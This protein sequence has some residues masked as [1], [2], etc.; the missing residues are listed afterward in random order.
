MANRLLRYIR[1]FGIQLVIVS[2]ATTLQARAAD[3]IALGGAEAGSDNSYLYAGVVRPLQ[4]STLGNGAVQR[5][6]V[7]RTTYTYDGGNGKIDA[8]AWGVEAALG[9][10]GAHD[11]TW[12]GTYAALVYRDT[13]L[14]PDDPSSRAR[15]GNLRAKVQVE[16]E[17]PLSA[18]WRINGNASYV[19]GQQNYWVRGRLLYRLSGTLSTGPEVLT[20]GDPDY[21]ISQVGWVVTGL[22]PTPDLDLALKLGA[23]KPRGE[24]TQ[25]Y[26]GI[27]LS[28]PF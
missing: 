27:E 7:D 17:T 5:Y 3:S 4:G 14:S 18:S 25:G 21:K 16:G 11:Q 9:Y 10:Q 28:H 13:H 12:W 20:Q 23:K 8:E 24:A 26:V 1:V 22:R 2:G 19:F 15:G 6:W